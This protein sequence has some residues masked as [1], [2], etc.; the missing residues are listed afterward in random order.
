MNKPRDV[1]FIISLDIQ[2]SLPAVFNFH[3]KMIVEFYDLY[4]RLMVKMLCYFM[5]NVGKQR[6]LKTKESRCNRP[7]IYL[8]KSV[9]KKKQQTLQS[10]INF[11][12]RR[13]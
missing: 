2:L 1:I 9:M 6:I 8:L 7:M 4:I 11:Y 3:N 12:P 10:A 5:G 13:M